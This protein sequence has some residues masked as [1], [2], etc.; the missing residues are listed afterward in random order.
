FTT[1]LARRTASAPVRAGVVGAATAARAARLS[2]A[3]TG[4]AGAV[5][6]DL[7]VRACELVIDAGAVWAVN[8]PAETAVSVWGI[9]ARGWIAVVHVAAA[10]IRA[11]GRLVRHGG[12]LVRGTTL[13]AAS[14]AG[15]PPAVVGAAWARTGRARYV[16]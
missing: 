9:G 10:A 4:F 13:R 7:P 1:C 11:G 3:T 6:A 14:L 2:V 8:F 15:I 12:A 5:L 16:R